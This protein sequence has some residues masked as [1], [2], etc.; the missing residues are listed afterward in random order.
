MT[1]TATRKQFDVVIVG[2]GIIGASVAYHLAQLCKLSIL[3]LER[4][5]TWGRGSTGRATGGYRAQ[6]STE[7]NIQLSL[8]AREFLRRFEKDTGMDPGYWPVGYLWIATSADEYADLQAAHVLQQKNGLSEAKLLDARQV[9]EKNQFVL[10]SHIIGGAFC[11]TDGFI[12]PLNLLRGYIEEAQRKGVEFHYD[13]Q[14][15]ALERNADGK[16]HTVLTTNG[17]AIETNAVVDAAG[18]WAQSVAQLANIEL[19]VRPLRRQVALT[20]PCT[21]L[22][23]DTP[24]TIF[25]D[26]GFHLR[27]RD[28]RILLLRPTAE[29]SSAP[30]NTSLD[31]AWI[32]ETTRIAKER[33]PCLKDVQIDQENSWGGLYEMSPD[34]H[35]ILGAAPGCPNLYLINGSSGHGVMHSPALGRLLAEIIVDGKATSLDAFPLRAT[36]F[37]EGDLIHASDRL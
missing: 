16:I 15:C 22:P 26:N 31:P 34:K 9:T 4:E 6:Y 21:L 32:E 7:I 20:K 28:D 1:R 14:V 13:S 29:E 30:Y 23:P 36:R 24:L 33:I 18:A 8:L 12:R 25:M 5:S 37:A 19:P 27:V 11:Q 17:L 3:V 2:G 35:A 10:T